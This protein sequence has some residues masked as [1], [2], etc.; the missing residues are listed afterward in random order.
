MRWLTCLFALLNG[1]LG[2]GCELAAPLRGTPVAPGVATAT[3]E[4]RARSTDVVEV[5]VLYPADEAAL[6]LAGPHPAVVLVQGG[7][8]GVGRYAW[9]GEALARAG[10][11]VALPRHDLDLAFFA[12]EN[13]EEARRLLVNPPPGSLLDGQ[14]DAARVAVGGH[15]LGGVVAT[16]LALRGGFQ[17]LVLEASYPDGADVQALEAFTLP[18]LSLAG[19]NDCTAPLEKVRTGWDALPAPTALSVLAGVTHYQFTDSEAEDA[20]RG[21]A[22]GVSL[23]EAHAR[24]AASL[25]GF[26]DAVNAGQGVGETALKAVPGAKVTTR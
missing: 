23:D 22:A 10:Y 26:L 16:K 20:T 11:V 5:E 8:V 3:F 9:Q 12:I 7:R 25:V 13:G 21:C 1:L 18:S 19:A 6:P 2:A 4:V 15:S 14:V 17:A 24:V